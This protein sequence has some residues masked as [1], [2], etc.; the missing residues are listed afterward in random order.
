M[1]SCCLYDRNLFVFVTMD[2]ITGKEQNRDANPFEIVYNKS[3]MC[4]KE[5]A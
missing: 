3:L 5:R 2:F 4:D 1:G